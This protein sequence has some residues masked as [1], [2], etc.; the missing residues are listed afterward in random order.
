MVSQARVMATS[1]PS[2]PILE[3]TDSILPAPALQR[4]HLIENSTSLAFLTLA[5]SVYLRQ[6][7]SHGDLNLEMFLRLDSLKAV[8]SATRFLLCARINIDLGDQALGKIDSAV[9][10]IDFSIL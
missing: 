9:L 6:S 3:I 2:Q 4:V 8:K 5:T 1:E 10:F 7:R